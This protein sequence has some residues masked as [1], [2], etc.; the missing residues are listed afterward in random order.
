MLLDSQLVLVDTG[1][2][3]QYYAS[4]VTRTFP[5][6]KKFTP[7]QKAL[8][9]IVLQA[10]LN[11]IAQAVPGSTLAKV[12]QASIDTICDGLLELGLLKGSK[13]E[14]VEKALF[15]KFFPHN[16]SHW[17]GMDVH[18]LGD[19]VDSSGKPLPLEA[20][21]YFSVEP[22]LYCDPNDDTIP[23]KFRGIGIRIEDDVLVTASGNEVITAGIMKSVKDLESRT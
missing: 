16:T 4:D 10:E 8:Y 23:D 9:E 12:H 11:A 7:E 21:M 13:A 18:D 19:Y 20:G 15:K 5:V 17:I 1:V 14:I 2:Q 3:F 6:G 22:G